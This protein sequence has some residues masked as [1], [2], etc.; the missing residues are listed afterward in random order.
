MPAPKGNQN[1]V[2]NRGGG[3]PSLYKPEYAEMARKIALL[4]ATDA[5]LAEVFGVGETTLNEW[6]NI[7]VEFSE[8]LKKGK[9][10]ADSDV[11]DRLYR[12]AMGFEHPDVDLRVV[13]GVIVETPITKMYPPDTAA[14]IF[15]L[16]NRQKDKWR[17]KVDH[18]HAGKDGAP[19]QF[20]RVERR[21]IDPK[22]E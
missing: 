18:E 22:S 16:K 17:D 3:R 2:G 10:I 8:A 4:G 20:Q 9:M 6:K 21:I 11:A 12:R 19:I 7:H 5:E 14:A 1:A 15:W 13:N